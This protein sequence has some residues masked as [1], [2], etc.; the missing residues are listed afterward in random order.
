MTTQKK[1][2][3]FTDGSSYGIVNRYFVY[4]HKHKYLK[5]DCVIYDG[6]RIA[7]PLLDYCETCSRNWSDIRNNTKHLCPKT[8]VNKQL[9]HVARICIDCRW[10]FEYENGI[11]PPPPIKRFFAEGFKPGLI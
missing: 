4:P 1:Q 2:I 7:L 3:K 9:G 8:T 6:E 5:L 10:Y 11:D